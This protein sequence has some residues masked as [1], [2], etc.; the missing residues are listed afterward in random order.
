MNKNEIIKEVLHAPEEAIRRMMNTALRAYRPEWVV[1]QPRDGLDA[2]MRFA[3]AGHCSILAAP[4]FDQDTA[5]LIRKEESFSVPVVSWYEVEWEGYP[6]EAVQIE[7]SASYGRCPY[8]LISA[9]SIDCVQKF[10]IEVNKFYRSIK[11]AV[12][13]FDSGHWCVD[14]DLFTDIQAST[15]ANLILPV[16][17]ADT[18]RDDIQNWIESRDIYDAERIPWKRGLILVG[19]PGHGKTHLNKSLVNHFGLMALYVRTF[20]SEYN[21]D[22]ENIGSVFERARECAPCILIFEDLDSLL[23]AN[24]RSYFLNE[25]DGFARNT[26]ILTVASANDPSKLDP[27]LVNRPSRFDRKYLFDLPAM[28]ER[29]RYLDFFSAA[30]SPSCRLS[31]KA[32]AKL[33]ESTEGFSYAYLKELVLSSMMAWISTARTADFSAVVES[34]VEM[35]RS[36]MSFDP[37]PTPAIASKRG[38]RR[39]RFATADDDD[40]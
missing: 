1:V 29:K 9:P 37:T 17:F 7:L 8:F 13:V 20:K 21:S 36:Q 22:A 12:M 11:G 38:R 26:G 24:N 34:Q 3:D 40:D 25:L 32:V 35:L 39:S 15:F 14:E 30:L 10:L 4:D 31:T 19:P 2:I 28:A 16:G 23:D 33:A 5:I 18:I 27:A 6:I